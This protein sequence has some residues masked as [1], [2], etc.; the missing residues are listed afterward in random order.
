LM[1]DKADAFLALPGGIGT[2]E[3]FFEVWAWRQLGYHDKPVG[4][5]NVAGYYDGLMTFLRTGVEQQFISGA[6]MELIRVGSDVHELL[7]ELVQAAG[8]APEAR[9]EAI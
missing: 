5:I 8:M 9:I 4:L 6:Q 3:E 7:P 2:F 1:A